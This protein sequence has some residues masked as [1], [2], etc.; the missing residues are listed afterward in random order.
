[1][2]PAASSAVIVSVC[3]PRASP[4]RVAVSVP[5][6]ASIVSGTSSPARVR[7][8]ALASRAPS[9]A[10]AKLASTVIVPAASTLTPSTVSAGAP[11]SGITS[12]ETSRSSCSLQNVDSGLCSSRRCAPSS[13]NRYPYSPGGTSPAASVTECHGGSSDGAS[14]IPGTYQSFQF[15]ITASVAPGREGRA[16]I[17][18][19]H[20][21]TG[22]DAL[23][24]ASPT[25]PQHRSPAMAT[26]RRIQPAVARKIRID[27]R[28]HFEHVAAT[29]ARRLDPTCHASAHLLVPSALGAC[30][31]RS[32][33]PS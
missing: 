19:S 12:S 30:S 24:A 8:D 10:P 27:K 15:P 14:G 25:T 6:S 9:S 4:A 32:P 28:A 16:Q 1:V 33:R 2:R 20:A 31:R 7:A 29:T 13:S 26:D 21:R 17:V 18:A 22:G 3:L 11:Q 23:H 5:R